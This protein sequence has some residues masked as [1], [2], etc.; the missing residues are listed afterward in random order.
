MSAAPTEADQINADLD[1]GEALY[2]AFVA[3]AD[4]LTLDRRPY[5]MAAAACSVLDRVIQ[6]APDPAKTIL[7]LLTS[8]GYIARDFGYALAA[9][10]PPVKVH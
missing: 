5:V 9:D 3:A 2:E 1:A 6:E 10:A 8:L 4:S 7:I